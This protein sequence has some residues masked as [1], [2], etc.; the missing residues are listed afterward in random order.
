[1]TRKDYV[2]LSSCIKGERDAWVNVAY[3]QTRVR[4]VESLAA[5]IGNALAADNP[6]FQIDR[7]MEACGFPK[8]E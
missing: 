2:L 7:F 3:G 6:A 8:G 4:A 1:M 5:R